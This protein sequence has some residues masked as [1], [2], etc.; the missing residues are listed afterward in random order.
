MLR[1]IPTTVFATLFL[2]VSV[3]HKDNSNATCFL[4]VPSVFF[5]AY[6]LTS[7]RISGLASS[8]ACSSAACF[9]SF[10]VNLSHVSE[11]ECV[12]VFLRRRLQLIL[13]LT[14]QR[15]IRRQDVRFLA[16]L[17]DG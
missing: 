3:S 5:L 4:R 14:S 16:V 2:N 12:L 11:A 1:N 17:V 15:F 6:R 7:A 8:F 9:V 13:E 10:E